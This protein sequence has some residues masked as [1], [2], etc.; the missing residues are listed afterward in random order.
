L[1]SVSSGSNS[2]SGSG[3]AFQSTPPAK[4][5]AVELTLGINETSFQGQKRNLTIQLAKVAGVDPSR[6]EVTIV[7]A[8]NSIKSTETA[9]AAPKGV[10]LAVQVGGGG[11]VSDTSGSTAAAPTEPDSVTVSVRILPA[12]GATQEAAD[13]AMEKLAEQP[14]SLLS[15]ELGT[16][17]AAVTVQDVPTIAPSVIAQLR[18]T[19]APNSGM[20][21]ATVGTSLALLALALPLLL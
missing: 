21:T 2:G 20:S 11:G 17:V 1:P 13:T 7:P 15:A 12:V 9:P 5:A 8:V 4:V 3:S 14:A 6:V 10:L 16:V 19:A 18:A